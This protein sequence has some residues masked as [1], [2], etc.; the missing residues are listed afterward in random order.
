MRGQCAVRVDVGQ[1]GRPR[2]PERAMLLFKA[3]AGN[4]TR[5]VAQAG[6]FENSLGMFGLASTLLPKVHRVE[7]R[8]WGHTKQKQEGLHQPKHLYSNP[9]SSLPPRPASEAAAA[10]V[11]H[12]EN[13]Q[14]GTRQPA[15]SHAIEQHPVCVSG[16]ETHSCTMFLPCPT[17]QQQQQ[18]CEQQRCRRQ[19]QRR[20]PRAGGLTKQL[21]PSSPQ[22]LNSSSSS[23]TAAACSAPSRVWRLWCQGRQ[24]RW[25]QKQ[26]L[27][28]RLGQALLGACGEVRHIAGL[29][30]GPGSS[31]SGLRQAGRNETCRQANQRIDQNSHAACSP[32]LP[33]APALP[34]SAARCSTRAQ[35]HTPTLRACCAPATARLSRGCQSSC[36]QPATRTTRPSR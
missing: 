7:G 24:G 26:R 29:V 13:V 18:D 31:R 11:P 10:A 27:P 1:R 35:Q 25:Q 36:E 15:R 34:R 33:L 5:R 19:Q 4:K 28:V 30:A 8:V 16:L 9:Y 17:Q 32:V 6:R 22:Q 3:R 2:N 20:L 21:A 14:P 12:H 23:S